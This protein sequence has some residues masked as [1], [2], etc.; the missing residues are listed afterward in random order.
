MKQ[1]HQNEQPVYQ[2]RHLKPKPPPWIPRHLN[3][4]AAAVVVMAL[5]SVSGLGALFTAHPQIQPRPQN[6]FTAAD[7]PPPMVEEP[8]HS[9]ET[10]NVALALRPQ[11]EP[12]PVLVC[13]VDQQDYNDAVLKAQQALLR[14]QELQAKIAEYEARIAELEAQLNDQPTPTPTVETTNTP[15]PT[16]TPTV[17]DSTSSAAAATMASTT[18]SPVTASPTS[19]GRRSS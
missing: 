1:R 18:T 17:T 15:A 10:G 3:Q 5:I 11:L 16:P 19:K 7:F 14:I 9:Y 12:A 4:V 13:E 2:A 8:L 6:P